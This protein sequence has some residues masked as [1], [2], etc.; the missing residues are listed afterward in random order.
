[1][2]KQHSTR[3]FKNTLSREPVSIYDSC[4]DIPLYNF[5]KIV[6]ESDLK[7]LTIS[8]KPTDQ[9]L[10]EAWDKI[11]SEYNEISDSQQGNYLIGLLREYYAIKGKI[12]IIQAIVDVLAK[13][14]NDQLVDA[15]HKAGYRFPF[16]ANDP[17]AYRKDLERTVSQAK[18]MVIRFQQ[19]HD[20]LEKMQN[21]SGKTNPSDYDMIL[22]ELS[23]YQ[24][25][26]LD[27]KQITV[28]EFCAIVKRFKAKKN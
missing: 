7:W 11:F 3:A 21:E 6:C 20:D 1:M 17:A 5:I 15:L 18:T 19:L 16:N 28:S 4:Q 27:P 25:Y 10:G 22:S 12:E 23:K 24:G 14:R 2:Q 13:G 8:G 9:E 26:R